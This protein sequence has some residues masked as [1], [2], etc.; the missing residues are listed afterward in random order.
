L[1]AAVRDATLNATGMLHKLNL[2]AAPTKRNCHRRLP[3]VAVQF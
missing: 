1:R 2:D 3:A